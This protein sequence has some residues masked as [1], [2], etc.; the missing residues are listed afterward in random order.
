MWASKVFTSPLAH[1][2]MT[3]TSEWGPNCTHCFCHCHRLTATHT[4][5]PAACPLHTFSRYTL[6]PVPSDAPLPS[7][8]SSAWPASMA[9]TMAC[10]R[11]PD[12]GTLHCA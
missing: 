4:R 8:T 3:R 10:D 11:A 5:V 9:A 7:S 2:S 6:E 1:R 12:T